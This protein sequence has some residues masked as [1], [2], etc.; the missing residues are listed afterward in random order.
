M[1]NLYAFVLGI[2]AVWMPSLTLLVVLLLRARLQVVG[3]LPQQ[4]TDFE[5][6]PRQMLKIIRGGKDTGSE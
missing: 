6:L 3:L 2:M 1:S 5:L 4:P